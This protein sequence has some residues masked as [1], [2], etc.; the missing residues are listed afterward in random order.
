MVLIAP[1]ILSANFAQLGS[2]VQAIDKAGADYIHLDVMDGHFVPNITFGAGI[3]KAIRPYS[4]KIFDAHLMISPVDSYIHAFADAGCDII[5]FHIE[6]GAHAHR[7]IQLI[8]SLGKKVGVSLNPS[9]PVSVLEN[10]LPA[11]DLVLLMSVNPGFGGQSFLDFTY[12]KIKALRQMIDARQLKTLIQ[13]DGGVTPDNTDALQ[14]VGA[15]VLVAG[16]A[17]FKGGTTHYQSNIQDLRGEK[18]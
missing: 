4:E 12:D 11:L 15:D 10:I 7:T 17:A 8:K 18:K 6:A 3:I 2:E 14:Q 13:V 9:T 1:S 5:T 16:S